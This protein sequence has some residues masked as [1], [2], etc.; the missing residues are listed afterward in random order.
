[1]EIFEIFFFDKK[2]FPV[3]NVLKHVY[4]NPNFCSQLNFTRKN[5][6]HKIRIFFLEFHNKAFRPVESIFICF[7]SSACDSLKVMTSLLLT[8]A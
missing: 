4:K 3:H 5:L 8:A 7:S 6:K 2:V 1:M